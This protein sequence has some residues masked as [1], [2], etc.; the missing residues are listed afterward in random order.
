M[1]RESLYAK[2]I[3][4]MPIPSVEAIVLN[5]KDELLVLKRKNCPAKDEWWFPGGR[6]RRG[7]TFEETLNREVREETGLDVK[8]IRFLGAYNRIFPERHDVSIVFL[9]RCNSENVVLNNEHSEYRFLKTSESLTNL[10]PELK[11]VVK[12]AFRRKHPQ[13]CTLH[14]GARAKTSSTSQTLTGHSQNQ[15][16]LRHTRHNGHK[17][18]AHKDHKN[19]KPIWQTT[20]L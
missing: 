13:A 20:V 1:I 3:S 10:H 2:I 4:V 18:T 15:N 12:D 16:T 14:D 11:K 7:E 19:A 9:C 8:I 5:E 6:M 17:P